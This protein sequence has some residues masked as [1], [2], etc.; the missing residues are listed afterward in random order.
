M[1]TPGQN[2][3]RTKMILKGV[4]Q[5]NIH[6]HSQGDVKTGPPTPSCSRMRREG[7]PPPRRST[8][9]RGSSHPLII[10]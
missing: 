4:G 1:A 9:I 2:E 6:G 10:M 3:P 5:Q 7:A 8:G